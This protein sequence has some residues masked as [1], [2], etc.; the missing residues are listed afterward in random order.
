V[1]NQMFLTMFHMGNLLLFQKPAVSKF[2]PEHYPFSSCTRLN[3]ALVSASL[4]NDCSL[5]VD[6]YSRFISQ[7]TTSL[8]KLK[9]ISRCPVQAM[10]TRTHI[11]HAGITQA[12]GT[13]RHTHHTCKHTHTHHAH[14]ACRPTHVEMNVNQQ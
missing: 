2:W 14:A 7:C 3:T 9:P 11:S 12:H 10:G 1:Q 6:M 5:H 13:S 8:Q 4:S